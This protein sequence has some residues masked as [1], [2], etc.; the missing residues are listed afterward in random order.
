M[1]VAKALAI[2][3]DLDFVGQ[4]EHNCH[5]AYTKTGCHLTKPVKPHP[6]YTA[7]AELSCQQ[8]RAKKFSDQQISDRLGPAN[9]LKLLASVRTE[10]Y[11]YSQYFTAREEGSKTRK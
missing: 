2:C 8:S 10:L 11:L 1:G 6:P 7:G 3:L 4:A 9:W 5:E